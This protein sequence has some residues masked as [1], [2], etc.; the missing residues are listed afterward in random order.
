MS[1]T[2]LRKVGSNQTTLK[3]KCIEVFYSYS[4]PVVIKDT[5]LKKVYYTSERFSQTTTKHVSRYLR[6]AELVGYKSFE[7]SQEELV[8]A[9]SSSS[10]ANKKV[11]NILRESLKP[12]V[13]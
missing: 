12:S 7:I 6:R 5:F 2:R 10:G 13:S 9:A 4:T 11:R 3:N 1:S 8:F